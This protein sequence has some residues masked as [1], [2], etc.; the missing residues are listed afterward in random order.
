[1]SLITTP[2]NCIVGGGVT[3]LYCTVLVS[4]VSGP[5]DK[6]GCTGI[7][8]ATVIGPWQDCTKIRFSL[9]INIPKKVRDNA[10]RFGVVAIPTFAR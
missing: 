10:P 8:V 4:F 7:S 9:G 5:Q 2:T 6:K 1:M 3:A